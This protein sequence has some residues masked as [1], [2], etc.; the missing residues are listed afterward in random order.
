MPKRLHKDKRGLMDEFSDDL[1]AFFILAFTL[2]TVIL[3]HN[4]SEAEDLTTYKTTSFKNEMSRSLNGFLEYRFDDDTLMSKYLTNTEHKLAP[5]LIEHGAKYYFMKELGVDIPWTLKI[6]YPR[7]SKN[8]GDDTIEVEGPAKGDRV[9][10]ATASLP[11]RD[12]GR[13]DLHLLVGPDAATQTK[14]NLVWWKIMF[15]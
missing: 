4:A 8:T 14:A 10:V 6:T 9:T 7:E 15:A 3:V 11:A 12:G 2:L 13:I 1:F 5:D